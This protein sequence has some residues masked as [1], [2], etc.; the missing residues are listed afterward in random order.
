M[1]EEG[2][3]DEIKDLLNPENEEDFSHEKIV[4]KVSIPEDVASR[5]LLE[6]SI[7]SGFETD[8]D[9]Q[10]LSV[11]GRLHSIEFDPKLASGNDFVQMFSAVYETVY[12]LI[13]ESIDFQSEDY[14]ELEINIEDNLQSCYMIETKK[15]GNI[16]LKRLNTVKR[17]YLSPKS[18]YNQTESYKTHLI[19][20][21]GI[22]DKNK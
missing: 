11:T 14:E 16:S 19:K 3:L 9:D 6:S 18:N 20:N 17:D 7:L 12:R 13:E 1:S 21:I 2:N 15:I 4:E 5:Y 8:S 22:K 10:R